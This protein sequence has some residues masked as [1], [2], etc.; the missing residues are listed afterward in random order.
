[1]KTTL[2]TI[3]A[4]VTLITIAL[5]TFGISSAQNRVEC[6]VVPFVLQADSFDSGWQ[7]IETFMGA[8]ALMASYET[9][10]AIKAETREGLHT[11][12]CFGPGLGFPTVNGEIVFD[13]S[14]NASTCAQMILLLAMAQKQ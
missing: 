9:K 10:M 3:V 8:H 7:Q 4:K 5:G 13:S 11:W 14:D 6:P 1:M 12:Y 2:S